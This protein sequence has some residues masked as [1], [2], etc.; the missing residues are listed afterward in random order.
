MSTSSS[1]STRRRTLMASTAAAAALTAA[2][3][4]VVVTAPSAFADRGPTVPEHEATYTYRDPAALGGGSELKLG[5]FSDLFPADDSGKEFWTVTDRGPNADAADDSH[6]VFLKP[7]YTPRILRIRL[8]DHGD[9]IVVKQEIPLRTPAGVV[10]PV[11]GG[12]GITGLPP[13]SL[14]GEGPVDVHGR[15]LPNDPYGVDSEGVVRGRD[16]SFWISSEYGS[17]ILHVS[18]HGTIREVLA[19]AGSTYEAPG[20]KVLKVLPAIEAKQKNNRG[21]EGLTVSADGRTLYAAQQSPLAN[22]NPKAGKKSRNLRIFKID[23]S[24]PGAPAVAAEFVNVR[25]ADSA[26]DGDWGTSAL[27]W[28]GEDRLLV[29]ER[30]G[31]LPTVNTKLYEVDL[32]EATDI[33]GSAWDN[34]SS[35]PLES[36]APENLAAAGVVPGGKRLVFDAAANGLD[37]GKVEG[38]SLLPARHGTV[39]LYLANDN[40]FGVAGVENG[41]VVPND[42]ATRLDVYTLPKGSVSLDRR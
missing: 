5:G 24:R 29:E 10:D 6:K 42:V 17:T 31:K 23:V 18:P 41:E 26:T 19:P 32:G 7:D 13:A 2:A 14:T 8:K 25:D 37:N 33:L 35:T 21:L 22:P 38:L 28:L 11:T 4:T 3:V 27:V 12:R 20:V 1:T 34:P 40:D 9:R 36:V 16:G 39:R 30:D 15:P